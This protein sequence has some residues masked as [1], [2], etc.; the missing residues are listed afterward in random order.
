MCLLKEQHNF[1]PYNS[2]FFSILPGS[3]ATPVNKDF[4]GNIPE[5]ERANDS[6]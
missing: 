6:L 2:H 3:M 1:Q 5:M 4:I